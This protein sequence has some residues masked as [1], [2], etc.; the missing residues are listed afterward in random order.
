MQKT[1]DYAGWL[2]NILPRFIEIPDNPQ[3]WKKKLANF[4]N[5][6]Y[7][8]AAAELVITTATCFEKMR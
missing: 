6:K 8:Y 3:K 4:L 5:N 2:G 7:I 1:P